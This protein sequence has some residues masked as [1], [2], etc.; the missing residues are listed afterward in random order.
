MY[1]HRQTYTRRHIHAL[2]LAGSFSEK[3]HG[4]RGMRT[5]IYIYIYIYTHTF[6]L[7]DP[8]RRE[9][10]VSERFIPTFYTCI[11]SYFSQMITMFLPANIAVP[12][13]RSYI[14]VLRS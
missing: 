12:S 8:R 7:F 1:T 9:I 14:N 5:H 4:L 11:F 6:F 10:T 2:L 3:N 13:G